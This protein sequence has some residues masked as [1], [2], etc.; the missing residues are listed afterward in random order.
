[1]LLKLCLTL[2]GEGRREVAEVWRV[3]QNR[4]KWLSQSWI[5]HQWGIS[6]WTS[7]H[8][9]LTSWTCSGF[10]LEGTFLVS[11]VNTKVRSFYFIS[12]L[13]HRNS[14]YL[15]PSGEPVCHLRHQVSPDRKSLYVG[16]AEESMGAR[17]FS[18]EVRSPDTWVAEV[19][20]NETWQGEKKKK[21]DG[22][23]G[24]AGCW[25]PCLNTNSS[26]RRSCRRQFYQS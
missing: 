23:R 15:L 24:E 26:S 18:P 13:C 14:L 7:Y 16:E 12:I 9:K 10:T 3:S 2:A 6:P 4:A 11:E 22:R 5:P 19:C 25:E 17:R 21:H 8:Q 20:E 1:M